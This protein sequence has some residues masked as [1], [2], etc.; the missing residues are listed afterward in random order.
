MGTNPVFPDLEKEQTGY[1]STLCAST[2]EET[3]RTMNRE[4]RVETL[5]STLKENFDNLKRLSHGTA[6]TKEPISIDEKDGIRDSDTLY[7]TERSLL[8][9]SNIWGPRKF[10][11]SGCLAAIIYIDNQLRGINFIAQIMDRVIER[12]QLSIGVVLD[13]ISQHDLK[14]NAA[15]AILWA[16]VV[17]AI[18]SDKRVNRVWFLERVVD[19]C[20]ALDL[21][22]WED[23]EKILNGFLWSPAW[24]TR[25]HVLWKQ[26]EENRLMKYTTFPEATSGNSTGAGGDALEWF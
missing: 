25:G 6:D 22:T 11:T 1:L 23:A 5:N 8:I 10:V 13:D 17:G 20:D 15:R 24:H 16:L 9:L 12:L 18:A 3:P 4:T 26:V 2:L 14:E 7:R 21:Q 19:F